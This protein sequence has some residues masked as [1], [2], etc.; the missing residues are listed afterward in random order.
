M[1][2]VGLKGCKRLFQVGKY[3]GKKKEKEHFKKQGNHMKW[4]WIMKKHFMSQEHEA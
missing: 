4:Q 1:V 3:K 2:D